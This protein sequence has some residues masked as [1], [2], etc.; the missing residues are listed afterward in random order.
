MARP[1]SAPSITLAASCFATMAGIK[2]VHVPY[3]GTGPAV[4]DLLGG[5]IA[6]MFAPIPART[7]I[8]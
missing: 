2:L 5:H 4:T 1:A 6:M 7:A 8:S 3:K